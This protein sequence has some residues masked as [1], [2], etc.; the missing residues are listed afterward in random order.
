MYHGPLEFLKRHEKCPKYFV[1]Y[2]IGFVILTL[3]TSILTLM[4]ISIELY[5]SEM[6]II[7]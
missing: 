5:V 6:F 4:R 2:D 1:Q 3:R 7:F